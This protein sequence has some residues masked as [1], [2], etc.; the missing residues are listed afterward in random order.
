[1]RTGGADPHLEQVEGTDGHP[2]SVR[3]SILKS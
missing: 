1:V 2:S 3:S